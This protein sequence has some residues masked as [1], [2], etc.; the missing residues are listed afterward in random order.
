[1][2][3]IIFLILI[4]TFNTTVY[5]LEINISSSNTITE[6]PVVNSGTELIQRSIAKQHRRDF[7]SNWLTISEIEVVK[8]NACIPTSITPD[9]PSLPTL[10][11]ECDTTPSTPTA[12]DDC[13][14]TI[15]GIANV[16][17]PLS[18]TSVHEII[19]TYSDSHGNSTTQTQSIDWVMVPEI[20]VLTILLTRTYYADY[21][22]LI[23]RN[24]ETYSYQ[25]SNCENDTIIPGE[26]DEYFS[27]TDNGFY[28][29]NLSNG[30]CSFDSECYELIHIV[31]GVNNNSLENISLFPNPAQGKVNLDI[32]NFQNADLKLFS[33]EGRLITEQK[34]INSSY[35]I[36]LPEQGVYIIELSSSKG[37]KRIKVVR[38]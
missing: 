8:I 37:Q 3:K 30:K 36:E 25:W 27:P 19:W 34:D 1:M 22:E 6:V 20:E 38:H 9:I 24:E 10:E 17:F 32:G 2:K 29:V 12:T 14:N 28:K 33:T 31:G 26:V 23:V 35:E 21:F 15:Q 16:T 18:D 4:V 13:S 7:S 11:I 5:S